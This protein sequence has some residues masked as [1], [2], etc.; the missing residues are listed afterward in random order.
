MTAGTFPISL[1]LLNAP[2]VHRALWTELIRK[3]AVP[4]AAECGI[5]IDPASIQLSADCS[6]IEPV[7]GYAPPTA[8]PMPL[9]PSLSS[10][11]RLHADTDE[12]ER[13]RQTAK[14]V[15]KPAKRRD[16]DDMQPIKTFPGYKER[17]LI[18]LIKARAINGYQV[19]GFYGRWVASVSSEETYRE[20]RRK[21]LL[22]AKLA[23][24]D[25][26]EREYAE[27]EQL[28]SKYPI[29]PCLNNR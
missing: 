16:P 24:T 14:P 2:E 29:V 17:T 15:A 7:P 27:L 4:Y 6:R 18:R 10:L 5:H 19:G 12:M 20:K 11:E 21:R 28:C 3:V 25:L 8:E 26:D 22:E 1:E 13:Q 23:T 9:E